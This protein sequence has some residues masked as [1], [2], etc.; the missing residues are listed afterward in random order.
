MIARAD[1]IA[2]AR[3]EVANK[4]KWVHQQALLGVALDCIGLIAAVAQACGSEEAVRY[5]ASGYRTYGPWPLPERLREACKEFM[6][7]IPVH[8]ALPG[9]VYMMKF[10]EE[11]QHFSFLSSLEPAQIIHTWAMR[12]CVCEH[13]LDFKWRRRILG[14][15]RLR[16]IGPWP[17]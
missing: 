7:P 2:V 1:I 11:P 17:L 8:E 13:G 15:W 3:R 6:D 16:G 12:E 14:A 5:L 10:E 4:T 9:D